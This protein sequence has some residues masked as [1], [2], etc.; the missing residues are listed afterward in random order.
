M[1]A[2]RARARGASFWIGSLQKSHRNPGPVKTGANGLVRLP[3]DNASPPVA[4]TAN[5]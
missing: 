2:P 4:P 1:R 3:A 5:N